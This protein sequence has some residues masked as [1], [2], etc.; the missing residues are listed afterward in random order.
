MIVDDSPTNI[1]ILASTLKGKYRL[2]IA[3]SGKEAIER[4][5]QK[6]PHLILLDIMMPQMDGFEVCRRLKSKA[7]T[8]DIPIIFITAMEEAD[9]KTRGFEL[10][11]VDYITRPFHSSEV[12]AR[13]Q[14]H[15]TLR[16]MHRTLGEKNLI[17]SRALAE[18]RKSV[19]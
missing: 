9:Q 16:Q 19:V 13:V 6:L 10:G 8:R 11:A 14:T 7:E 18:D 15:L 3:K 5:Y 2:T 4:V 1:D 17:I 12:L